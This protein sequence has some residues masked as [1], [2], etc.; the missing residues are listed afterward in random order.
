MKLSPKILIEISKARFDIFKSRPSR[1]N[2]SFN[3]C[4]KKKEI[5][6]LWLKRLMAA[7]VAVS[8]ISFFS[9][10]AAPIDAS[11]A[12]APILEQGQL[13]AMLQEYENQIAEQTR[14]IADLQG[15]GRTLQNEIN[16]IDARIARINLQIRSINLTLINLDEEI[17]VTSDLIR[18]KEAEIDATE[19]TIAQ[20]LQNIYESGNQNF[21]QVFLQNPQLSDFFGNLNNLFLLQ[22]NLQVSLQKVVALREDYLSK[23]EQLAAKRSDAVDLKDYQEEQRSQARGL[24]QERNNLLRATRGREDAYQKLLVETRRAA[25]EIRARLIELL[26][27]PEAPTLGQALELAQGVAQQVG[28]RPAFLLAIIT[29]ESALGRNVGGCRVVDFNT[30]EGVCVRL[31]GICRSIGQRAPRT[32]Q[33]GRRASDFLNITRE[34]GRDPYNTPVSCWIRNYRNGDPFG[35]G[36]AMGPAQFIPS[37]WAGR[38]SSLEPFVQGA[39]DPWNIRHAF[40]ASALY[41][42][43]L[44]GATNERRAARRYFAGGNWHISEAAAYAAQVARIANCFQAFIDEDTMTSACQRLILPRR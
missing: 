5:K 31:G 11:P 19:T 16:R 8:S 12:P 2:L 39:P 24:R 17:V 23:K 25:A 9:L 37:T 10:A 40:L 3:S 30:G 1:L 29:Q 42:R 15:Q 18:E 28:I 41:L 20:A 22:E 6:F 21:L 36:G 34:L 35:W 13:E 43:D 27:I 33:P 4:K 44:G 32:M 26:D 14:I 38:R 7:V